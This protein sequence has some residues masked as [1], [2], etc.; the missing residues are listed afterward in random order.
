MS[1]Y[2]REMAEGGYSADKIDPFHR[3]MVP[4]LLSWSG[5]A[6]DELVFDIGAGQGHSLIPLYN[7]G[8]SNLVAVDV[9]DLNF[10]SFR[11]TYGFRTQRC[12]I[13]QESLAFEDGCAS[14][15]L[16]FH[17]IE[18][19]PD[20]EN[21]LSEIYRVLKPGGKLFL[22]TPDWRKQYKIFYSLHA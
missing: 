21:L 19:L 9:D 15:V 8:W 17:L 13:A 7:A 5:V 4:W 11:E 12:D 14:A 1:G 22:V 3:F 16:C 10:S 18:H 6:K 2:L 20:P